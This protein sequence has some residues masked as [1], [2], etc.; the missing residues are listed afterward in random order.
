MEELFIALVDD[1]EDDL[2][3][4]KESFTPYN[5]IAIRSFLNGKKF[6]DS[7]E[8]INGSNP[9]LIVIDLNLPDIHGLDLAEQIKSNP[10][11]DKIPIIVYTTAYSPAELARC[12]K[13]KIE[14]F[15][16]PSTVQ[17]WEKIALMMAMN[18]SHPLKG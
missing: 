7:I 12:K 6:L 1:D 17:H 8:T 11:L 18:C 14:I 4:L 15:R 16:K 5:S 2:A 10:L 9:C 3:I 13:L